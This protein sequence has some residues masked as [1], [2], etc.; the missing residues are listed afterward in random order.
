MAHVVRLSKTWPFGH[1]LLQLKQ[2][3]STSDPCIWRRAFLVVRFSYLPCGESL[4]M[5]SRQADIEKLLRDFWEER[6]ISL[7]GE[8]CSIEELGA[9]L[10]SITS[11]E[12]I[13]EID[14]LLN[15]KLPVDQIIRKG[16]YS[17]VDDFV[18]SVCSKVLEVI[19][20]TDNG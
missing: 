5:E 16:G 14:K 20:E 18:S 17:D 8:P 13:M 3:L 19:S 12:A 11:L 9:P 15:R 1:F 4:P 6:A 2:Y 7:E 10:D